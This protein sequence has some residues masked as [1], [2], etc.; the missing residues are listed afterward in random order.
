MKRTILIFG[1]IALAMFAS[2]GQSAFTIQ[3]LLNVKRVA[4]PQI[5]PDGRWV[6]YTVGTVNKDANKVVNQIFVMSID[7]SH[8]RQVT[9]GT[10]SSAGPRWSPDGKRIAYTTGGQV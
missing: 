3:D 5:S 7:G 10:S 4:D 9:N 2:Y 8:N 1:L 6:A